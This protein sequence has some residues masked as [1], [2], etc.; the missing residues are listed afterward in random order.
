MSKRCLFLSQATSYSFAI[1]C[2]K[3][4]FVHNLKSFLWHIVNNF[5]KCL[6][7]PPF[8]VTAGLLVTNQTQTDDLRYASGFVIWFACED[9]LAL[10]DPDSSEAICNENGTWSVTFPTCLKS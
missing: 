8:D 1:S 2:K 9:D 7:C 5:C 10:S 3:T 6:E 4:K